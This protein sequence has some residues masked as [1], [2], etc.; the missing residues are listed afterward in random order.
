MG[1]NN[2]RSDRAPPGQPPRSPKA[3]GRPLSQSRG[4]SWLRFSAWAAAGIVLLIGLGGAFGIL[5][6]ALPFGVAAVAL[7]AR[8]G[9]VWPEPLGV[10]GGGGA[11]ALLL[12]YLNRDY[13]S[14][15]RP[16]SSGRTFPG[17]RMPVC[18]GGTN[19]VF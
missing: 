19:P 11:L 16:P 3:Q 8:A 5:V 13:E 14:C 4:P 12:A 9:P 17:T 7:L 15:S 18:N 10:V 6:V 1:V 2:F